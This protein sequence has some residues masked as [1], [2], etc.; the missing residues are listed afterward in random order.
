MKP[1][2][3]R[4]G[5][6]LYLGDCL[7]ILPHLSGVDAV[8]TDPPYGISYA[9][10]MTG[11]GGGTALPGIVGDEDCL[12]RDAVIAWSHGLPMIVFGTWK[13]PK[14]NR[15][16]AVLTWDKGDHVG[17]GDL[18]L[19][20]K[21]NT[22]EIYIVGKGFTGHRGG[23]VLRFNAPPTWNSVGFGRRHP[24]QKPVELMESL[25]EKCP[26]GTILDPFM[27]SG[28]TIIAC[29]R[30]GRRA[31]GIESDPVHFATARRRIER[32]LDSQPL[33]TELEAKHKQGELLAC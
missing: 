17:M 22:E 32:E 21:P 27:G 23:S 5:I 28:S 31:I 3:E 19:P 13:R 11:H 1:T 26:T 14:P 16:A 29:I 7:Q 15:C 6:Q 9:S 8:V 12:L 10:G 24:H 2:W 18:S 20:W 4:D 30:T 25:L 33:I